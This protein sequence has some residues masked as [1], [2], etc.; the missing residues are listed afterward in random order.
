M[1]DILES[2][3]KRK[4]ELQAN[5]KSTQEQLRVGEAHVNAMLGAMQEVD[6]TM[7]ILVAA[8]KPEGDGG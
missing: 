6:R 8:A 2:L 3:A 5:V 1:N 7:A 4:A